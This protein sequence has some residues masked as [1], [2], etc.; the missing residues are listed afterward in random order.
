MGRSSKP[1][2]IAPNAS[3]GGLLC[4]WGPFGLQEL[5]QFNKLL[6]KPVRLKPAFFGINRF[7][8]TNWYLGGLLKESS[9]E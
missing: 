6:E 2:T 1:M 7:H 4:R 3:N 8:S 5:A 9:L